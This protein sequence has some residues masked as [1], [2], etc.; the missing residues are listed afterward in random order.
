MKHQIRNLDELRHL[1]NTWRKRSCRFVY[2]KLLCDVLADELTKECNRIDGPVIQDE[3]LPAIPNTKKLNGKR[4]E[5]RKLAALLLGLTLCIISGCK[6]TPSYLDEKVIYDV[7][8]SLLRNPV[9]HVDL[10]RE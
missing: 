9:E 3:H 5:D 2:E 4:N 7:G 6:S 10:S 8:K 1:A